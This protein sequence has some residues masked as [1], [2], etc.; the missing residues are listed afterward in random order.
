[1]N[2]QMMLLADCILLDQEVED[3]RVEYI[4]NLGRIIEIR[5]VAYKDLASTI[6]HNNLYNAYYIWK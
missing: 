2:F 5:G 4:K 6:G 3:T 1:M